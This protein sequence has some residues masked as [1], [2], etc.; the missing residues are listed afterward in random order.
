M[1]EKDVKQT[2]QYTMC[3]LSQLTSVFDDDE[4]GNYIPLS[5]MG[6][7]ANLKCFIHALTCAS[8][9]LFNRLTGDNKNFLEFNH[10]ANSLCFEFG[11]KNDNEK[12]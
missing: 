7:G 10:V 9:I 8:A 6:E 1:K 12:L 3:I 11:I 4:C 2:Q 5:E